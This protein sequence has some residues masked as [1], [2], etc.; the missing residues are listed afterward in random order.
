MSRENIRTL[1]IGIVLLIVFIVVPIVVYGQVEVNTVDEAIIWNDK[2]TTVDFF[3]KVK[4]GALLIALPLLLVLV[5]MNYIDFKEIRKSIADKFIY[6]YYLFVLVSAFF[7]GYTWVNYFGVN[8]RYEGLLVITVYVLLFMMGYMWMHDEEEKFMMIL[9]IAG[10]SIVTLIG[11]PQYFGFDLFR[12]AFG[13]SLITP[14]NLGVS[15][16]DLTF[17]VGAKTIYSTLYNPNYLGSFYTLVIPALMGIYFKIKNK[18]LKVGVIV[19]TVL[20]V[21]ALFGSKSSAGMTGLAVILLFSM[22][23]LMRKANKRVVLVVVV[24]LLLAVGI[25]NSGV[26]SFVN[27]YKNTF[28]KAAEE[29]LLLDTVRVD[30]NLLRFEFNDENKNFNIMMNAEGQ[31]FFLDNDYQ[32]FSYDYNVDNGRIKSEDDRFNFFT[33]VINKNRLDMRMLSS[34]MRFVITKD[35][36]NILSAGN[37]LVSSVTI[38]D[39]WGLEGYERAGSGRG[40]IWSRTVPLIKD[41]LILGSGPDSYVF[42]FPQDDIVGK[43]NF[44]HNTYIIVDKPHNLYLQM[45][46]NS[47]VVSLILFLMAAGYFVLVG[48]YKIFK[49]SL[50]E[51]LAVGIYLSIVGYLATSF[52]NDS[53]VSIAPIFWVFFGY[54]MSKINKAKKLA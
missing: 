33:G 24:G 42:E 34:Y 38:A 49:G 3:H 54:G 25:F 35:G 29:R 22:L 46:I 2:L 41:H 37:Q 39:S 9:M 51:P 43:M 1:L 31:M 20:S 13:K 44:M 16:D 21:F 12:T 53:V 40:Y 19:L 18:K 6:G 45:A 30:N 5:G 10:V 23:L 11:V 47:G 50:K 32:K 27:D 14:D 8:G 28:N 52:F 26:K 36:W 15:I 48:F 4:A 17:R 7:S